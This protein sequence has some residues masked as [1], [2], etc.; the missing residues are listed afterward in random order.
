MV[1]GEWYYTT[2]FGDPN[3]FDCSDPDNVRCLT[4]Q[5]WKDR[6]DVLFDMIDTIP[7]TL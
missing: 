4:P 7:D 2:H 6:E 1:T 5:N 3:E